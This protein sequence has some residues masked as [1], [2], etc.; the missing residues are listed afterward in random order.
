MDYFSIILFFNFIVILYL[1]FKTKNINENFSSVNDYYSQ[2]TTAINNIIT[3]TKHVLNNDT[4]TFKPSTIDID[5]LNADNLTV[6][7]NG[8]VNMNKINGIIVIWSGNSTNIPQ[9]WVVC[10][11]TNGTPDL[12]T[13]FII[14]AGSPTNSNS[15]FK[16]GNTGGQETVTL[17]GD[18]IPQHSHTL[19]NNGNN[20][21]LSV[22]GPC[23]PNDNYCNPSFFCD[24]WNN[25]NCQGR[26]QPSPATNSMGGGQAHN[27]I[28][29][30]YALCYIM[31]I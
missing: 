15:Y 25:S 2:D 7:S 24:E 26:L 28:P 30:Y 5:Y 14:G 8:T 20:K 23:P 13:K 17:N 19:G 29:P 1:I 6:N 22:N 11:G 9:G 12:R 18:Q 31:K 3:Y 10:D 4:L 16:L 27:N 21:I